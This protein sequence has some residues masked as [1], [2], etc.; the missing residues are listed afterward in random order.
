MNYALI[1]ISFVTIAIALLLTAYRYPEHR[2]LTLGAGVFT[3]ILGGYAAWLA[4]FFQPPQAPERKADGERLITIHGFGDPA[5]G[6]QPAGRGANSPEHVVARLG[7]GVC[8]Q[9]PG[10]ASA[11]TG[12]EGPLLI[13]RVT[14]A[15]RLASPRY[16]A[17]VT[18]GQAAARTTREYV[19]ESIL[20]PSA[21]IVP[22]FEQ[23]STPAQSAMPGHFGAEMTVAE[24]EDLVEYL[25]TLDCAAALGEGLTGPRIEPVEGVC[26]TPRE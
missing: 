4:W 10:I 16:R 6:D 22:G 8:H 5:T 12:V 18:A 15:Q 24:L 7:C 1:A 11:R 13:P 20:T 14:A 23:P 17:A 19:V 9:I 21:Y 26:G 25:M 2:S 3:L